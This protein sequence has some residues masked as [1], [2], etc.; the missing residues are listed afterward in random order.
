MGAKTPIKLLEKYH[1]EIKKD[2]IEAQPRHIMSSF[3]S[4]W[5]FL[6]IVSTHVWE[7]NEFSN[8]ANKQYNKF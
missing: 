1:F 2:P 5:V 8:Q 6:E 3:G 7:A 4:Y